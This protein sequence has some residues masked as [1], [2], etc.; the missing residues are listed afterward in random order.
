MMHVGAGK[1][2]DEACSPV[3]V[4]GK[5]KTIAALARSSV[6]VSS[7]SYAGPSSPGVAFLEPEELIEN[8][9]RCKKIADVV[10][11][12]LHWGLEEYA[13]P[14]PAQLRLARRLVEAGAHGI[15]GHHPHVLQGVERIGDCVVAYSLGNFL[16]D[17]FSWRPGDEEK[18]IMFKLS[19]ANRK[20]MILK[21]E[22]GGEGLMDVSQ[23]YTQIDYG[24]IKLDSDC[25]REGEFERLSEPLSKAVYPYWWRSYALKR[26]W[27]LRLKSILKPSKIVRSLLKIRAHHIKDVLSALIR[28]SRVAREKST[29][30][31]E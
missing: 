4:S 21:M 17:E 27:D 31:Y 3:F 10:I 7:P 24:G 29:N 1:D 8:I 16:F 5:G 28:S 6:I 20:G 11:V 13:Y 19:E 30:P 26:E 18:D 25:E 23:V 15:I 12:F 14:A 2:S 22:W 9:A